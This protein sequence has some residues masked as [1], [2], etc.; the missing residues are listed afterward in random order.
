MPNFPVDPFLCWPSIWRGRTETS[1]ARSK[2]QFAPD[3]RTRAR[4]KIPGRG[5]E[6]FVRKSERRRPSGC[7]RK[8]R[9]CYTNTDR[10]FQT[11]SD[12]HTNS[13]ANANANAHANAHA[14]TNSDSDSDPNAH[15]YSYPYAH[16]N[17]YTDANSYADTNADA[18]SRGD[19]SERDGDRAQDQSARRYFV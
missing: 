6:G 5:R 17:S 14:N 4:F 7:G 3:R 12:S 11:N 9:F 13:D 10:N 1:C 15:S 19:G 8:A 2:I 16:S 18:E